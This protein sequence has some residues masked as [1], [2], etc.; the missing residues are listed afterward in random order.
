MGYGCTSSLVRDGIARGSSALVL[1]GG[2]SENELIVSKQSAAHF[3]FN[4]GSSPNIYPGSLM[5][6]IALLRQTY[7]DAD[8]YA[9]GETK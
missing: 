4:K 3:S 9:K 2:G 5:G 6:S 7:Y 1:L 8:W